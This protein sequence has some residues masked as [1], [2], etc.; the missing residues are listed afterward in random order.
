MRTVLTTALSLTLTISAQPPIDSKALQK[1][2][3][4][5]CRVRARQA[6]WRRAPEALNDHSAKKGSKRGLAETVQG[7]CEDI[8]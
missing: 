4:R 1:A 6:G 8:S 3:G 5:S 2:E 7:E